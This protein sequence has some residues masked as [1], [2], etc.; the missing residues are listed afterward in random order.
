M[1]IYKVNKLVG[2]FKY[3]IYNKLKAIEYQIT[4]STLYIFIDLYCSVVKSAKIST[5][6]PFRLKNLK[7]Y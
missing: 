7:K 5:I 1:N 6:I 3:E 2:T 4:L